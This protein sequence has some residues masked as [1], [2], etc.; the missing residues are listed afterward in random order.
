MELGHFVGARAAKKNG[1]ARD[2]KMAR[3][4]LHKRMGVAMD[5]ELVQANLPLAAVSPIGHSVD[6]LELV[7]TLY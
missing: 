7:R 2:I 5:R 3:V 1:G 6:V 4:Q